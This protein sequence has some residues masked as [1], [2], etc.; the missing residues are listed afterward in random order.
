V[1]STSSPRSR[2]AMLRL[3]ARRRAHYLRRIDQAGSPARRLAAAADLLRATLAR[4]APARVDAAIEQLIRM[5]DTSAEE[6]TR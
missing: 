3:A 2:R 5:S 1:T 4:A 6:S